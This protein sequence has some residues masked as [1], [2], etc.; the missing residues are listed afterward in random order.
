MLQER[1]VRVELFAPQKNL[2]I[3]HHVSQDETK[4]D[5]ACKRHDNF[6]ANRRLVEAQSLIQP[7]IDRSRSH[8]TPR[9][10]AR[11]S[12]G[13][14]LFLRIRMRTEPQARGA[15]AQYP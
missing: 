14:L 15:I 8:S 7:L 5:H 4:Q 6:F 10:R 2:Q 11:R 1:S 3:S 9:P 12:N 13:F